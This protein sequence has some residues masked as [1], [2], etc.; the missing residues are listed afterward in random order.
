MKLQKISPEN[1]LNTI[2]TAHPEHVNNEYVSPA[3]VNPTP[4][5]LDP[6]CAWDKTIQSFLEDHLVSIVTPDMLKWLDDE[7]KE[8][9]ISILTSCYENGRVLEAQKKIAI[10]NIEYSIVLKWVGSTNYARKTG[11]IDPWMRSDHFKHEESEKK[12]LEN[13]PFYES[14]G[15]YSRDKAL[16]EL[17]RSQIL[18]KMWIDCEKVLA[19]Y[20]LQEVLWEN[21]EYVSVKELEDNN[22]ISP[23]KQPVI[24]IRAHKTNFRLL[25]LIILDKYKRNKSILPVIKHIL[26]ESERYWWTHNIDEYIQK[27]STTIIENRLELIWKFEKI[28]WE[29]WKDICRNISMFW[30]ELD[31][32]AMDL[33]K[34]QNLVLNPNFY[35]ERYNQNMHQIFYWLSQMI[36]V[37]EENTE[38]KINHQEL[39]NQIYNTLLRWVINQEDTIKQLHDTGNWER[40]CWFKTVNESSISLVKSIFTFVRHYSHTS[41]Y[42]KILKDRIEDKLWD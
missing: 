6:D 25:D 21:G 42:Q 19:I 18:D 24:L 10:N 15:I 11:A 32:W 34:N 26:S 41:G 22:I 7:I 31:L 5:Y 17:E 35:I 3:K 23:S 33:R 4:I 37:I 14:S 9:V 1:N 38:Y 27:L 28:N 30:E 40:W 12:A 16:L 13:F 2:F 29:I 36:K 20:E 8:N 39:A